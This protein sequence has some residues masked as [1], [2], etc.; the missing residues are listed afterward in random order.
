MHVPPSSE[1]ADPK[2]CA[3]V[4][5]RVQI[6]GTTLGRPHEEVFEDRV[7]DVLERPVDETLSGVGIVRPD[8]AVAPGPSLDCTDAS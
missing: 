6:D 5:E 2:G 3:R 8:T 1:G 4:E 7:N